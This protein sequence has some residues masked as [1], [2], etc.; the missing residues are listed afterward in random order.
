MKKIFNRITIVMTMIVLVLACTDESL[1]PFIL[2]DLQKGSLLALRG[3]DGSAGTLD[4]DQ[5]F[6][7]KDAVQTTDAFSYVADF[8]SEDQS[9]LQSV[10][11]Y[12]KTPT[13]TRTLVTT[14]DASGWTIPT[15]GFAKQGTVSVALSAILSALSITDATTLSRT[16]LVMTSDLLLTDGTT[17]PSAAI[18]NSG[19]FSASAFFPA[20]NLNYYAEVTA[21]FRPKATT[22]LASGLALKE[23][24][25]DTLFITYDQDLLNTPTIAYGTGATG[26]GALVKTADDKYYDIVTAGAGF[27]GNVTATIT[28]GT[29]DTY[30]PVLTQP[31]KTQTIKVDNTAPQV[32]SSTT[33]TRVGKGQLATITINFNEK[34]S[35]KSANA[36]KIT[37]DDPNDGIKDVDIVDSA[38]PATMTLAAN[39]LSASYVFLVEEI[40]PPGATHGPLTLTYTGGADEAGNAVAGGI[41]SAGLTLDVGTPPAPALALAGDY[42]QGTQI[43]WSAT[44]STGGS[45]AGGAVAGTVY[46]VAVTGGSAAPTAVTFDQD[47]NAIWTMATGVTNQGQGQITTGSTGT[48]GTVFSAFTATGTFD[49]YAV[50]VGS[51]G[52]VS[53]I[54][55]AQLAGV[56]M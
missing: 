42:D 45:N 30:G 37:I 39:G 53:A 31:S 36:I 48:S 44:Q 56:V 50:F 26:L 3:N 25:K 9:L 18:V 7:F 5:N 29:A 28:G 55:A 11:V 35:A 47:A 40:T 21:D 4:P 51:T 15:G 34:M 43:K 33:G 8:I 2:K 24:A 22:K 13:S 14:I 16:D 32:V 1:D 10:Q 23:A 20:S 52:N 38:F 54:P 49:F 6:F 12:A 17:V 19:L 41:T 27:T 46:F